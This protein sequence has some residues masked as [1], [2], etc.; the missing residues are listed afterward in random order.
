MTQRLEVLDSGK[1]K[2]N[3]QK[4]ALANQHQQSISVE[5]GS[6]NTAGTTN[7]HL[8]DVPLSPLG[9]GNK[10]PHTQMTIG[11]IQTPNDL[12]NDTVVLQKISENGSKVVR[13]IHAEIKE[14]SMC[15]GKL[16]KPLNGKAGLMMSSVGCQVTDNVTGLDLHPVTPNLHQMTLDKM[17]NERIVR[18]PLHHS[19]KA[20]N[21]F[22]QT[23]VKKRRHIAPIE[24]DRDGFAVSQ[25][26]SI[27]IGKL[28]IPNATPNKYQ[29]L[30]HHMSRRGVY[31]EQNT[32]KSTSAQPFVRPKPIG[33]ETLHLQNRVLVPSIPKNDHEC[34]RC[35][36][37]PPSPTLSIQS[38]FDQ[39]L[40]CCA[41]GPTSKPVE[42]H[43]DAFNSKKL[44]FS[45]TTSSHITPITVSQVV[46]T[47]G[48]PASLSGTLTNVHRRSIETPH[49]TQGSPSK[50][51]Q[52]KVAV[53]V[54]STWSRSK[55]ALSILMF[56]YAV[57]F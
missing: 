39:G 35:D 10:V 2:M 51:P 26:P 22:G 46:P 21:N 37:E 17:R 42:G 44:D 1:K 32:P 50:L 43:V 15:G 28:R 8:V 7:L 3:V 56:L 5:P 36:L 34:H 40:L 27:E 57:F 14:P 45:P 31:E 29:S 19:L 18:M 38:D 12:G 54:A 20:M 53:Q 49:K 30:V 33:F 24:I 41:A 9:A 52:P 23:P 13:D 47:L 55:L 4:A 11:G 16:D 48:L 25:A 6:Q